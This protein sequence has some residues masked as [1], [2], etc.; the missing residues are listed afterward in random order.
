MAAYLSTSDADTLAAEQLS[1]DVASYTAA[2]S[3]DKL[4]SL[5]R[6]SREIDAAGPYQGRRYDTTQALE[7]PRVAYDR[8]GGPICFTPG[9]TQYSGPLVWDWDSDANQAAIPDDVKLA[10][11]LQANSIL[12]GAEDARL[13]AQHSG[14]ASQSVGGVSESYVNSGGAAPAGVK[15][16]TRKAADLMRKYVLRSGRLL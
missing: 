13:D 9:G 1:A 6:A 3:G 7:F 2:S 16:L 15:R 5:D 10:T 14:L 11:L 4:K 12:S 8:G